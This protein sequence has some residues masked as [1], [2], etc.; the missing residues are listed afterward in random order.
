MAPHRPA[1]DSPGG[2]GLLGRTWHAD[3]VWLFDYP[4]GRLYLLPPSAA[5]FDASGGG[6]APLGFQVDSAGRRTTHFP[7]VRIE[8]D[9]DSLDLL[10]DTGAVLP[11][12]EAALAALDDGGPAVRGTSF[13]AEQ[14]FRR[15]RERHPQWRVIE[16]ADRTLDMPIIEVPSVTIAGQRV[17]PVWF[18]MRR[19]ANFHEFMSRWMDRRVDGALGGSA[20]RHFRVTVDYPRAI[21]RFEHRATLR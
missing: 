7:R 4:A 20:L 21:A 2:D 8:V 11:L 16:H 13:I 10:F 12:T 19:D 15:W 14:V 9:G 6:V 18:T 1:P 5:R 17:G 3:R